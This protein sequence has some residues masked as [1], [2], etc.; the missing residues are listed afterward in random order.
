MSNR[1]FGQFFGTST[2]TAQLP[3][4]SLCATIADAGASMIQQHGHALFKSHYNQVDAEGLAP[5]AVPEGEASW[6]CFFK[7]EPAENTHCV[8]AL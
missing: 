7:H 4:S 1:R 2:N 5:H 6:G 8:E 3:N